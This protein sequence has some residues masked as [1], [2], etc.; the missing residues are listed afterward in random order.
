MITRRITGTEQGKRLHRYLRTLMPNLPLGQLYGMIDKGRVRINGK[1]K[2][3]PNYELVAGDEVTLLMDEAEFERASRGNDRKNA[4]FAGVPGKLDIVHEDGELLVVCKPAGLLTHP[5][6]SEWKNTLISRVHAYLY[7][8]GELDSALFLPATANRL[9]RNTSGLVLVGKT[10][11]MLHRLNRWIQD[12]ELRKYYLT[13]VEGHLSGEGTIERPLLRNERSYVTR[14]V[15][16]GCTGSGVPAA[17]VP[18]EAKAATTRY[19]A[20]AQAGGCTLVEAELVSGRTHQIRSHFQSIGHP[21]LGDLKYGGRRFGDLNHQLLHAWRII[22]P[23]GREFRAAPPP[24]MRR[25]MDE[26]GFRWTPDG[27]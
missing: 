27:S 15:E 26:L 23:D 1:R 3:N 11:G 4:K 13:I 10:A 5:D 16:A 6:R 2:K 12:R 21:L 7:R 20:L 9:D 19:R 17:D 8:K 25:I 24:R 14:A 22:L 18:E